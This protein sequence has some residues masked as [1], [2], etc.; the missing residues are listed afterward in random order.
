LFEATGESRQF[1]ELEGGHTPVFSAPGL[2]EFN[3]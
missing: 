2:E 1:L 3:F